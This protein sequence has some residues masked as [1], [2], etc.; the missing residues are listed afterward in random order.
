M[1]HS[2]KI[3]KLITTGY[4]Y[5]AGEPCE[6]FHCVLES[7]SF[8]QKLTVIEHSIPFFLPIREAENDF[9]SSN[10]IVR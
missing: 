9:L 3:S 6:E 7:K 10:A 5:L 8:L 1:G 4:L 2:E